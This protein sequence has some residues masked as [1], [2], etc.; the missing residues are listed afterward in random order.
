MKIP[1]HDKRGWDKSP[2][3]SIILG[4]SIVG[5]VEW[6]STTLISSAYTSF[7]PSGGGDNEIEF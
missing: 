2:S 1:K 5:D 4:L 3:L 6:V 7:S